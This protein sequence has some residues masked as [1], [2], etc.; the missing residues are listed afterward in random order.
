MISKKNIQQKEH[1][2]VEDSIYKETQLKRG[3]DPRGQVALVESF[4]IVPFT[5]FSAK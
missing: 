5:D 2:E 4:D 1:F 3:V